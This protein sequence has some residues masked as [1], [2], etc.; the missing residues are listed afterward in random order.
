MYYSIVN[1]L[2]M[3]WPLSHVYSAMCSYAH[4]ALGFVVVVVVVVLFCFVISRANHIP[5]RKN[6]YRGNS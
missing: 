5:S 6:I 3:Y 2:V 4:V 1:S